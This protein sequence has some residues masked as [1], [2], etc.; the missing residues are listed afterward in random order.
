MIRSACGLDCYDACEIDIDIEEFPKL[1]A[2]TNNGALCSLLNKD[3]FEAKRLDTPLIDGIE[4]TMEEALDATAEALNDNSLLWRGSGNLGVMQ[5]ITNLLFEKIGGSLTK[6]SLCDGA[7]DAGIVEGRGVNRT[8]PLEQIDKAEV[9]IVWGR[10][11][12]TT[13]S[14]LMPYLENKK[15]VVIDPIKTSIAKRADLFI[16]IKPR[17]DI[18]FILLLARFIFM[19]DSENVEWLKEFAPEYEEFYDFTRTFRIKPILKYLELSLNDIGEVLEY[20]K[21]DKVVILVGNGVQKYEIG[22]SV[23]WAIDSLASTLGL[24]GK[25]GCGVS[26]LGNSKLGFNSIFDTQ[27][28]KV[29]K[30][31]TPFDKFKTV[32]IQGGNPAES[33]PNSNK[34]INDL[35]KIENLIYFGLYENETSRRAK[36]VIPAKNFFEKNDVRLS[37][38]DHRV[39]K[40]NKAVDS[41]IGISEYQFTK[42]MYNRLGFSGLEDEEFYINSW[43]NQCDEVNGKYISPAYQELPYSDGFGEDNDEFIFIDDF[44][45]DFSSRSRYKLKAKTEYWLITSKSK[46]AMNTQFRRDNIVSLNPEL[47]YRDGEEITLSSKWGEYKFIVKNSSD[48]RYDS[49]YIKANAIGVNYLTPSIISE[50]GENAC[51]QEVKINIV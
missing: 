38:G 37:Y 35:E 46:H 49:L 48:I 14:H 1:K 13:N 19:E 3:M 17:S 11:I 27:C 23:L 33:M 22:H 29:S 16:Q 25:E 15:L 31:V 12:S 39:T 4:V 44:D 20:I 42:E 10:D 18:Y 34:V 8:L 6:G 9:I 51:Y 5:E 32:L 40:M 26:Y 50:E 41:N 45:N 21:A 43:L 28:N 30:A 36:I 47:G 24:F 7:G 2:N